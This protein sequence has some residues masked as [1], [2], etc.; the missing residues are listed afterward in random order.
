MTVNYKPLA[1]LAREWT[2]EVKTIAQQWAIENDMNPSWAFQGFEILGAA[3]WTGIEILEDQHAV[4]YRNGD[5]LFYKTMSTPN[6]ATSYEISEYDVII[7]RS[8]TT[9]RLY[10]GVLYSK[11]HREAVI[12]KDNPAADEKTYGEGFFVQEETRDESDVAGLHVYVD[13]ELLRVCKSNNQH[14]SVSVSITPM[15]DT[16]E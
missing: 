9:P 10:K 3:S 8:G 1:L 14:V 5:S 15:D 16:E 12:E 11:L 6:V 2:G 13:P 7:F 4:L